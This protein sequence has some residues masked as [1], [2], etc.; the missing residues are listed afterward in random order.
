[1]LHTEFGLRLAFAGHM[2]VMLDEALAVR[3][4]HEG[5]KSADRSRFDRAQQ[6]FLD[7]YREQLSARERRG[8]RLVHALRASGSYSLI[9]WVSRTYRPHFGVPFWR[10]A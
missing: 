3:A 5:A 7:L 1:M 2:P 9:G 10:Q 6:R 8:L 4:V